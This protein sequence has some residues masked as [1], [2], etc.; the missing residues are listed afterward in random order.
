MIIAILEMLMMRQRER[1]GAAMLVNV[2]MQYCRGVEDVVWKTIPQLV[3]FIGSIEF[4]LLPRNIFIIMCE[5]NFHWMF[6][7]DLVWVYF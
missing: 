4:L 5:I 7:C 1:Q 6:Y 3:S 2:K